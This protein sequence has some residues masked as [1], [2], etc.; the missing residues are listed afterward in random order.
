MEVASF[1]K[2][3][4]AL[5]LS[6][7]GFVFQEIKDLEYEVINEISNR[8]SE[9]NSTE[10]IDTANEQLSAASLTAGSASQNVYQDIP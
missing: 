6:R 2:I 3:F 8:R 7:T 10:C 9:V 4:N 1:N 5:L